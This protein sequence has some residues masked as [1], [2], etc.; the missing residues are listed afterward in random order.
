MK[1]IVYFVRH[2]MTDFTIKDERIRPLT[3]QGFE[4]TKLIKEIN[5]LENGTALLCSKS[6]KIVEVN[7][8]GLY[9]PLSATVPGIDFLKAYYNNGGRNISVGSDAHSASH[10]ARGFETAF[11]LLRQTGFRHILLPW[12]RE[13]PQML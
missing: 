12:D 4:D 6:D 11:E 10:I 5:D 1:T 9:S 3:D 7:T 13:K 8:S 2:S